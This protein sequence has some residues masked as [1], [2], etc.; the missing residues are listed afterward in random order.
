MFVPLVR[1]LQHYL[2]DATLT[3]VISEPAYSLVAGLEGVEFI[4]IEKPQHFMDYWRFRQQLKGRFFDVLIA[5][6]ASF[7]ANLLYPCI[8]AERKIGYDK[9]RA[10]DGHSWFIRESISPGHDHTLE[11]FLKFSHP[12]GVSHPVI[13]WDLVIP[14]DAY[15]WA[16]EHVPSIPFVI[17]NPA[18]SKPERSWQVERYIEIIR[19]VQD[20]YGYAVVLTGGPSLYDKMLGDVIEKVTRVTNLIGKTKPKQLLAVLDKARFVL[21]PDTGPSHMAAAVNTPVIALHA[22]THAGVSG[23]YPF[24]KYAVNKYPEAV[25]TVLG[26]TMETCPWGTHIHGEKAMQLVSVQ[27]VMGK[28]EMVLKDI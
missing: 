16:K 1:T 12:L 18:A 3:W 17:I 4:V 21:C 28:I 22:V 14:E 20:T 5:A 27:D 7:R 15:D 26:K 24:L 19:Y 23:P 25:Q 11:G 10:K 2:P 13:R 9:R 8:F 6:Q